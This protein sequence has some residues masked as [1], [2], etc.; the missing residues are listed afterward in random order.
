MKLTVF[1]AAGGTGKHVVAESLAAGHEVTVL[2]RDPLKLGE[3]DQRVT[4]EIGD[5]RDPEV[6]AGAVAG[7]HGVPPGGLPLVSCRSGRG[8]RPHPTLGP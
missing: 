4:V 5:A 7:A 3:V 2:V 1:G 6:V 8:G